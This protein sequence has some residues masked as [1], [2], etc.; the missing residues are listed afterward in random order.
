MPPEVT[1][2]EIFGCR[3]VRRWLLLA[4]A[5][6]S[7]GRGDAP[8]RNPVAELLDRGTKTKMLESIRAA[9]GLAPKEAN[10]TMRGGFVIVTVQRTGSTWLVEEIQGHPCLAA[11]KEIF[12][13]QNKPQN[14]SGFVWSTERRKAALNAFYDG[15]SLDDNANVTYPFRHFAALPVLGAPTCGFKWML[16]QHF[17]DDWSAWFRAF[18]RDRGVSL[19]F[20]TRENL[21]RV[22][23]SSYAKD[24]A[25]QSIHVPGAEQSQLVFETGDALLHSLGKLEGQYAFLA[26][27]AADARAAGVPTLALRYEDLV[28]NTSATLDA[29]AT[30]V[31][32]RSWCTGDVRHHWF[33]KAKERER[34][35]QIHADPLRSYIRNWDD[36]ER[37]LA[38]T[39]FEKYLYDD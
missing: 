11:G 20:L 8:T 22:R 4:C 36:V 30:Y 12:L 38:G 24:N 10:A 17:Q 26:D 5:A 39:R 25:H 14:Y 18:C 15:A 7:V 35:G 32:K 9:G 2:M 3:R 16:S 31:L 21:L 37:T 33:A 23:V 6:A 28:A 34:G 29:V 1:T 27:A 13:N 19:I